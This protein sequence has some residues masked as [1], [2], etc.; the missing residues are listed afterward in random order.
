MLD[1]Y[2]ADIRSKW[3]LTVKKNNYKFHDEDAKDPDWI[4]K[5]CYLLMIAAV[6]ECDI[7]VENL[8]RQ[9]DSG[10]RHKFANFGQYIPEDM[11]NA[12]K[13]AAALLFADEE[14]WYCDK[15]D[16]DWDVFKPCLAG[17]N[18]QRKDL[19]RTVLLILDESMSGWRPKTSQY[20]GFPSLSFE[21]RKPVSLGTLFRNGCECLGGSLVYQD[22]N[23]SPEL[24]KKKNYYY[25]DG[26]MHK[27][28]Q[29]TLFVKRYF[30][31]NLIYKHML[32]KYYVKLKEL[33]L[34]QEDGLEVML[35]LDR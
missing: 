29:P 16:K 21:P 8:W 13:H 34:S 20:G 23:M 25:V 24:Q 22:I 17:Y 11:F 31:V 7:G 6:T 9:G 27:T 10:G 18:Q 28:Q 1:K 35:G 5:Q 19:F 30:L 12:W 32:Q 14:W 4:I 33:G 2:H 26:L 3:H 15:R